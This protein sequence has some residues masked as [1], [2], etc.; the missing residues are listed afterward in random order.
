M[1]SLVTVASAAR[2]GVPVVPAPVPA[3]LA[4]ETGYL[5][6]RAYVLAGEWV[7][8]ALPEGVPVRHYEVLQT[9]TD[10]GPRSQHQLSELLWVNRTIMVKVVDA[11]ESDGLVERRRNPADRRSYALRPTTPGERV[12]RE[13][14]AAVDLAEAGLTASLARR[15]HDTL[16]ALLRTV[17]LGGDTASPLPE[18]LASRVSFLLSPAH[19]RVRE[20][21]NERLGVLG[22]T[23][24]QYGPLATIEARAPISQQAIADQLGLT[25]PAIVQTVDRLEASGLVERR[26]DPSDRRAYALTT[27][28]RGRATL[29]KA[30]ATIA[31][32]NEQ[33]AELLGGEQVRRELNQRLLSLLNAGRAGATLDRGPHRGTA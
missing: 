22:L 15:E 4:S 31:Q 11:L 13:L 12:R 32:I 9:L 18:V 14:S 24:G 27:T 6:R 8:A 21:V 23:T 16:V 33:L 7:A 5:L 2:A 19:H 25:G 20:Q 1:I 3:A 26:R 29:G 28:A 10:L 30:R 17:A